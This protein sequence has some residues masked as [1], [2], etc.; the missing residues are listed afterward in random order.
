MVARLALVAGCALSLSAT[1]IAQDA[2][3][4]VAFVGVA[5]VSTDGPDRGARPG[6]TV[7][8][9][10]GRVLAV[11]PVAEVAVPPGARRIDGAGR[12]LMP[13]LVDMHAHLAVPPGADEGPAVFLEDDRATLALYLAAGVT[14]IRNLW[15]SRS[16][17]Q[18]RRRVEQ[19][20]WPGPR[21]VTAGPIVDARSVS[22]RGTPFD[23]RELARRPSV[24]RIDTPADAREAVRVHRALGYDLVKVYDGVPAPAFTALAETAAALGIPVVGHV[25]DAVGLAGVLV[26]PGPSLASVEH[27]VSFAEAAVPP[28]APLPG[29]YLAAELAPYALADTTRLAVWAEVAA[30][31]GTAVVPTLGL[32]ARTYGARAN[33]AELLAAIDAARTSPAQRRAWRARAVR[34]AARLAQFDSLR[35]DSAAL[36]RAPLDAGFA[37]VRALHRAGAPLVLGTDAP[38]ALADPGQAVA[39]ELALLTQA[40]LTP[41]DAL[42]AA[43]AAPHDWFRAH[44][45]RHDPEWLLRGGVREGEPADLVLLRA[46]PTR[47]LGAVREVEAVVARG[48]LWDRAALDAL[49][50]EVDAGYAE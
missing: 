49:L 26:R 21:I 22:Q 31:R 3:D 37:L 39:A 7:V 38:A 8:V 17:L 4:L 34:H 10:E 32:L 27:T 29:D 41:L 13:G 20:V 36:G 15:G 46:D 44:L 33:H 35:L 42:R 25:P 11:G 1:A 30:A 50:A 12:F 2:A 23:V 40:G 45:V 19:G 18:A 47:D 48:R 28:G 14:T 16:A 6:Q 24:L 9:G 5:V 43:T